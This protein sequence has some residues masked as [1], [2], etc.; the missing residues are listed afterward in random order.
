MRDLKPAELGFVYGAA[1][2][3]KH[4]MAKSRQM[5]CGTGTRHRGHGTDTGHHKGKG[6]S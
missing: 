2:S 6:S 4:K 5:R 1:G 3:G